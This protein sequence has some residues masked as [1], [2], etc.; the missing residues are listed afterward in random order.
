VDAAEPRLGMAPG[1][2]AECLMEDM[3]LSKKELADAF[4]G[5]ASGAGAVALR[6]YLPA[7][8]RMRKL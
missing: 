1:R 3:E 8:R 4:G 7:V 6:R 5:Y 2:A